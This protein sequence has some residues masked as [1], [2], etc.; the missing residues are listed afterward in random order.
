MCGREVVPKWYINVLRGAV[1]S[2]WWSQRGLPVTLNGLSVVFEVVS[3]W[4]LRGLEVISKGSL[5]V[6]QLVSKGFLSGVS[7]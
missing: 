1:V 7:K 4:S 2:E 3:R 6:Y 5:V